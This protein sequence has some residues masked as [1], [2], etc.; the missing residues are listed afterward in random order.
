MKQIFYKT[1]RL[2]N[3]RFIKFFNSTTISK[4]FAIGNNVS[5]ILPYLLLFY[6]ID[7]ELPTLVLAINL[8]SS[9]PAHIIASLSMIGFSFNDIFSISS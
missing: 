8:T 6:T 1:V 7:A 5:P 2:I 4:V 9:I 3:D